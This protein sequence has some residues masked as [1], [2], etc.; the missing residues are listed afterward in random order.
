MDLQTQQAM[1]A[2]R[3]GFWSAMKGMQLHD[4]EFD[5]DDCNSPCSQLRYR[6]TLATLCRIKAKERVVPLDRT[7]RT[8][9]LTSLNADDESKRGTAIPKDSAPPYPYACD[10]DCETCFTQYFPVAVSVTDAEAL[11]GIKTI[12]QSIQADLSFLRYALKNHADSIVSRWKKKSKDKRTQFLDGLFSPMLFPGPGVPPGLMPNKY[13]AVDLIHRR[14]RPALDSLNPLG[15][16]SRQIQSTLDVNDPIVSLA[17]HAMNNLMLDEETG[18]LRTTWLLPY[19]DIETLAEDPLRLLSLL[20]FRTAYLPVSCQG[21]ILCV[22][23]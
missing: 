16:I 18:V 11:S 10:Q 15:L 23:T 21:H 14:S 4:D 22:P 7:G 9:I 13:G 5:E 8:S 3:P 1:K 6:A 2:E 17:I 19:L 20:H 12:S